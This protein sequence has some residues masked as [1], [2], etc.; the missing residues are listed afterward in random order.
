MSG[1][2]SSSLLVTLL[3]SAA[4][5][6][7]AP[8]NPSVQS[9][10]QRPSSSSPVGRAVSHFTLRDVL[11]A[12]RSLDDWEDKKAVVVVFL[13][14]E[15]PLARQYGPKLGEMAVKYADKRV[16]FVG[17]DSNQHDTLSEIEHFQRVHK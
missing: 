17:I 15:C 11:G 8:P 5:Q 14:A 16:Q 4:P 10:V 1:L 9:R 3:L 13:C 6:N 7:P 12:Q 2:T